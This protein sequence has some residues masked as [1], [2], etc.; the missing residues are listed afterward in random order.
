MG[1]VGTVVLAAG[2]G[3]RMKSRMPKVLHRVGGSAM[4]EH[5]LRAADDAVASDITGT[6]AQREPGAAAPAEDDS[7]SPLVVVVGHERQQVQGALTWQPNHTALTYVEQEPQL[8]TGDAVQTARAVFSEL[9]RP[10]ETILVLYGD[11][12]LV[13]A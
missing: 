1:R 3:T 11:T 5:V 12:P 8:G 10:P 6:S 4:L 9:S 7:K 2:K 13:R